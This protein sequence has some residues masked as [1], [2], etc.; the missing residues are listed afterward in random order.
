MEHRQYFVGAVVGQI[1]NYADVKVK[2]HVKA[3]VV[4]SI[5][6]FF[7]RFF[8]VYGTDRGYTWQYRA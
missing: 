1:L 2:V 8:P 7:C 6:P 3:D 4:G 5:Q